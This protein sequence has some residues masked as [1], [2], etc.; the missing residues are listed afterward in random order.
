MSVTIGQV[1]KQE[2]ARAWQALC[3]DQGID[4]AARFAVFDETSESAREYNRAVEEL[5]MYAQQRRE[6]GQP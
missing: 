2:V 4:P 5:L 3:V 6:R 1:L